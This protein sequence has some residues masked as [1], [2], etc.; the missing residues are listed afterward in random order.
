M[1]IM[2]LC[3]LILTGVICFLLGIA[4][5]LAVGQRN[6]LC[7]IMPVDDDDKLLPQVNPESTTPLLVPSEQPIS[8]ELPEVKISSRSTIYGIVLS[9]KSYL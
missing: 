7:W 3:W 2:L 6:I 1:C 9:E 5:T 8:V 4:L